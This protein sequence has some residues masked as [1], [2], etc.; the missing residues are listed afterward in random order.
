M[1]L[2]INDIKVRLKKINKAKCL[3]KATF[4]SNSS[5]LED[6][7]ITGNIVFNKLN[8]TAFLQLIDKLE[9][10]A[11]A[12]SLHSVTIIT[13]SP[14][15]MY[16]SLLGKYKYIEAAGGIV[17]RED[18]F[19]LIERLG[20]W[21]L[22]K[23]KLE[24]KETVAKAAVREVEEECN[25]KVKLGAPIKS[26]YHTFVSQ[27]GNKIIKRTYWFEMSCKSDV[28]MK[29]QAEEG[30]TDIRWVKK[31]EMDSYLSNSYQSLQHLYKKYLL[32]IEA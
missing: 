14:K 10:L 18:D 20:K 11:D 7:P 23:G 13:P 21:D 25:V 15:K 8:K 2:F 22:P 26:I 12:T 29:P 1:L 32:K 16:E 24:P 4:T 27:R 17:R 30:I 5:E 28:G 3:D 31:E 19:L 9:A 6:F